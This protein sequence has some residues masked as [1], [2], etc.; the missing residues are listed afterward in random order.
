MAPERIREGPDVDGRS[1]LFSVG[2]LLY[3]MLTG[4]GPFV[5]GTPAASLAAVLEV[6]VD[7]DSADRSARVAPDPARPVEAPLRASTVG[8]RDGHGSPRSLRHDRGNPRGSAPECAALWRPLRRRRR[9][10]G[11]DADGDRPLLGGAPTDP[12][13]RRGRALAWIAG[14]VVV[15]AGLAGGIASVRART[16]VATAS[17]AS[18][19]VAATPSAP[20]EA[21]STPSP[22]LPVA[23]VSASA[24]ATRADAPL[25]SASSRPVAKTVPAPRPSSHPARR[26]QPRPV[27]TT[28]GF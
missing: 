13:T 12:T 19:A 4:A 16:P 15:C 18:A 26:P 25:A 24:S 21:A 3:E 5:A 22:D 1:D 28:P 6:V 10:P 7:P 2:V 11:A 23:A 14:A 8:G 9:G 20:I 17:A 27:A